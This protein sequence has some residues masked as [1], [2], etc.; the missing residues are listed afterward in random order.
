MVLGSHTHSAHA[1]QT[2]E[3]IFYRLGGPIAGDGRSVLRCVMTQETESLVI[4]VA[5]TTTYTISS[6]QLSS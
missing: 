3:F 6:C 4:A 1:R 2:V 5:T